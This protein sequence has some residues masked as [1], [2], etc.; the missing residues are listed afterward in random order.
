MDVDL[1]KYKKDGKGNLVPVENIKEADLLKDK[2]VEEIFSKAKKL[3]K[4]LADFKRNTLE[5]INAFVQLCAEKY[6]VTVGGKKGNI[7]LYS[8]DHK[9]RVSI[10]IAESI[11]FD[12]KL[13][14]AKQLIDECI[15]SWVEGSNQNLKAIVDKAFKVNQNGGVSKTDILGLRNIKIDDE[16]WNKAMQLISDS[17][18]ISH[19]KEYIRVHEIKEDDEEYISLNMSEV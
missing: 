4:D 10:S 8:F 11:K 13:N 12:E 18:V 15:N 9:K 7:T 5:D 19:S 6:N 1:N 3:N 16:K 14:I 2:M 17:I